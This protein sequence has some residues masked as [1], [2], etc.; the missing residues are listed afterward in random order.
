MSIKEIKSRIMFSGFI[1]LV[2][3]IVFSFIG[4]QSIG[5]MLFRLAFYIIGFS[6]FNFNNF[7]RLRKCEKE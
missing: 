4:E 5:K 3:Y 7:R 1:W 2:L 6:V